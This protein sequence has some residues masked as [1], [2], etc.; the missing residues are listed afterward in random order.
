MTTP[1]AFL[2]EIAS[3]H[4]INYLVVAKTRIYP[5]K[6]KWI[7]PAKSSPQVRNALGHLCLE[8]L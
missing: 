2:S 1:I 5:F 6:G 8:D 3:A 7:G 4:L